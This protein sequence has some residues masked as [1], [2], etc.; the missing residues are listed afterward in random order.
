VQ[1]EFQARHPGWPR[2]NGL[3]ALTRAAYND[4]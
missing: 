1:E 4:R 3:A 2:A